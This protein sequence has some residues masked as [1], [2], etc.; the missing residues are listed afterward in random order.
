MIVNGMVGSPLE[1]VNA[2]RNCCPQW[3]L[4]WALDKERFVSEL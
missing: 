2:V 3:A 4:D 1:P